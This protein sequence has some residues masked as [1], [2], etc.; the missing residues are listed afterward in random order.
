MGY[1]FTTIDCK[2]FNL[3]SVTGAPLLCGPFYV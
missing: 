1:I 2:A 3:F